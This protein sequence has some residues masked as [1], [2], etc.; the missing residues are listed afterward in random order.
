VGISYNS[1]VHQVMTLMQQAATGVDR[2][3]REP[4]PASL[5]KGFGDNSVDLE[6]RFWIAD[7]QNGLAN[8][9]SIV[10]LNIWDVFQ[11]NGIEIPYPQ[12]D[13][14]FDTTTPVTVANIVKNNPENE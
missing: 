8:I 4:S 12:Q 3:L 5:L 1:D 7:P 10:M 11:E 14:H 6:L 9:R 2:V 13:I